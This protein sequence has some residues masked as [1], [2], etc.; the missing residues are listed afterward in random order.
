MDRKIDELLDM[1]EIAFLNGII[2]GDQ[3][4]LASHWVEQT[5]LDYEQLM[6]C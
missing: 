6:I 2:D 3:L 1:L 4:S 5:W